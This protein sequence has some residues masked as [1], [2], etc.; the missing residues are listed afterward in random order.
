LNK[1]WSW[2]LKSWTLWM[3]RMRRESSIATALIA[4]AGYGTV[5]DLSIISA[6]NP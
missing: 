3:R 1:C 2:E 6:G 5:G 4:C